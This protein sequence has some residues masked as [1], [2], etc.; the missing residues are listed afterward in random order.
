M[1]KLENKVAIVT[2]GA[3]GIGRGIVDRFAKE[4]ARILIADLDEEGGRRGVEE[5]ARSNAKA[6][7]QRADVRREEDIKSAVRRTVAEFGRLDIFVNNAGVA[8]AVGLEQVSVENWDLTFA[9]CMRS[10]FLGIKHAVPEMRRNGGGAIISIAS[11][12]GLRGSPPLHA[13]GAAKAGVINLT[14]SAARLLA[15]DRIRVNCI[16]PGLINSPSARGLL[17]EGLKPEEEFA[18]A[19]AI[20]QA[21]MPADIAAAVAF[22]ASDEAHWITGAHLSVDGGQNT[23][24]SNPFDWHIDYYEGFLHHRIPD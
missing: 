9:T 20:P 14:E 6:I 12:S 13:Y 8:G 3:N 15:P 5:C 4:G 18:K 7:F 1:G 24:A 22:F 16:C 23:S 21:G 19:Q 11:N 10:V 17:P 2:G